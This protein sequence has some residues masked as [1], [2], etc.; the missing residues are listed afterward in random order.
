MTRLLVRM[1]SIS[2]AIMLV[3]LASGWGFLLMGS[4]SPLPPELLL[5]WGELI[6]VGQIFEHL[7]GYVPSD[8][9]AFPHFAIVVG[10]AA[11]IWAIPLTLVL[12]AARFVWRA[13]RRNSP[14]ALSTD[15]R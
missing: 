7:V 11:A 2:L 6:S 8:T 1:Y 10:S 14:S 5:R 15:G 3:V 9:Q 13:A 12:Y 4:R